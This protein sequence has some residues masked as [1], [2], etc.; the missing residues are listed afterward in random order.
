MLRLDLQGAYDLAQMAHDLP[1]VAKGYPCRVL[2]SCI[3]SATALPNACL[4][5]R[6]SQPSAFTTALKVRTSYSRA[7]EGQQLR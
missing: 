5:Q 6:L 3:P 7:H 1:S 2:V 4:K